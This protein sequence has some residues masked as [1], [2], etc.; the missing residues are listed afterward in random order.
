MTIPIRD[1]SS[2]P[3]KSRVRI[4]YFVWLSCVTSLLASGLFVPTILRG[5]ERNTPTG[6]LIRF[7]G[8]EKLHFDDL[9]TLAAIDPPLAEL[10]A[11]LQ[12]VLQEPF[13]SNEATLSGAKPRVPFVPGVGPVLRIAE[14]NINR[15]TRG[16]E[17]KL[18]LSDKE[19]F[20][21]AAR[22]NPKLSS[23]DFRKIT[24]QLEHL[25]AADIIVLDEID[26]GVARMN[27]ENPIPSTGFA[28]LIIITAP[29]QTRQSA[30]SSGLRARG[31]SARSS[32]RRRR[33]PASARTRAPCPG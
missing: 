26:D 15:T 32:R 17:L 19:G 27:Y 10:E 1:G 31:S 5:A 6:E 18:A 11:R 30:C 25:Q 28:P 23:K 21:A 33:G 16:A 2:T 8:P 20:V 4:L 12:R 24:E 14:W 22:S 3:R 13:I 29:T 7:Q 9:V